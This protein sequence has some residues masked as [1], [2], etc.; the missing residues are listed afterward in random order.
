MYRFLL[1]ISIGVDCT[2]LVILTLERVGH[3]HLL[4]ASVFCCPA[5]QEVTK[6]AK[7]LNAAT[8]R[9]GGVE[10]G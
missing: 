4:R 9:G 2:P 6:K 8:V 10:W 5:A 1:V 3:C 7:S